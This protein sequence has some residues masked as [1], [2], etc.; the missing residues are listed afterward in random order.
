[1][2]ELRLYV[3]GN[4]VG[5]T[6]NGVGQIYDHNGSRPH[7]SPAATAG[8][9]LNALSGLWGYFDGTEQDVAIYNSVLSSNDILAHYE[10]GTGASLVTTV[11][12][13]LVT[14]VTPQGDPYQLQVNFNQPVVTGY[15]E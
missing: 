9:H 3:N 7:P 4:L 1:M 12:P 2:G 8:Q 11:P 10:A 5:R 15:G 14:G 6:T 13:T